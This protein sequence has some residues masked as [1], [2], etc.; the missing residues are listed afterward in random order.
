MMIRVQEERICEGKIINGGERGKREE[1]EKG[2]RGRG[3]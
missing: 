3:I 2:G 1:S